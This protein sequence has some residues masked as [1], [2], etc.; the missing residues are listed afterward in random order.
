MGKLVHDEKLYNDLDTLAVNLNALA[1]DIRENPKRYF[2]MS[3]F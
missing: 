1:K 3:I 2:N